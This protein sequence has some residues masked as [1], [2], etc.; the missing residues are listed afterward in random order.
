MKILLS[1]VA[2]LTLGF[3]AFAQTADD[4][5][6]IAREVLKT[7][8]KAAIAE[9]MM[10]DETISAQFWEL[11]NEFNNKLYTVHTKR[12]GI[13]KDY[14]NNYG[15]LTPEK[16]DELMSASINYQQELLNLKK[17]YYKKFKKAFGPIIAARYMQAENKIE[18][19]VDAELAYEIPLIPTN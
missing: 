9:A 18:A 13:I 4:Y 17:T 6:E 1:L 5:I 12:I 14:A 11:Y 3:G 7:E 8:K 10:L 16:A 19:M 15:S 2:C